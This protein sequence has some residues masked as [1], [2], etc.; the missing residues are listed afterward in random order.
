MPQSY[1]LGSEALASG[2]P[3]PNVLVAALVMK[4]GSVGGERIA[5]AASEYFENALPGE[6]GSLL[7]LLT[8]SVGHC[9]A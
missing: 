3:V 4:F 2:S 6:S 5:A 7:N 9:F 8:G 1:K